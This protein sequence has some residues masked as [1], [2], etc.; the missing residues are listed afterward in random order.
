MEWFKTWFDTPYYHI[1]YKDRDF[2]EA[3]Q[4][5]QH[6]ISELKLPQ[7]SQFIDLACGKGRHSLFLHQMGYRV[8]G[9]DLSEQSLF[10]NK[11]WEKEGLE[12]G[13]HDIRERI[14][15]PA[16]DAVFNLFTSF[17]YFENNDDN[18]KVFQSVEKA[19]KPN[20]LFVLDFLNAEKIK[21]TTNNDTQIITKEGID[22]KISKQ[23]QNQTIVK[24]ITFESHSKNFHFE[25]K[26][27]LL[28]KTDFLNY[29]NK[30][31]LSLISIWGNY[32]LDPFDN[33]ESDR[34][35][36]LFQKK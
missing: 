12:F 24:T 3:E 4:F 17:G 1:L 35:I 16:V 33:N 32:Q 10:H 21:K 13:L 9:L 22:F 29:S 2:K 15:Y 6:L 8:L 34:C 18:L 31:G 23:I 36:L 19:L 27:K 25:E 30:V 11:K 28:T 7:A 26:V 5:L 20:G 14:D